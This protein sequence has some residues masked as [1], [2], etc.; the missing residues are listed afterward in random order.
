MQT[1]LEIC[2]SNAII[3]TVLAALAAGISRWRGR[4]A[5]VHLL[6]V[7]VLL[8]LITPPVMSLPA[9]WPTFVQEALAEPVTGRTDIP[10]RSPEEVDPE[11]TSPASAERDQADENRWIHFPE[12]SPASAAA[13]ESPLRESQAEGETVL[14][15][16]AHGWG[17]GSWLAWVP[18]L[19]LAGSLVWFMTA[20]LRIWRFHR[21][22]HFAE[23]APER[24]QEQARCL[25]ESV[26]LARCP[27]IWVVPGRISPLLWAVGSRVRLVLPVDL[28]DRLDP[29]QQAAL[30]A[31]E[32]AHARRHDHWVRWLELL[33]IGVYWWH[34]VA[35]WARRELQQA[36]EQCCDAWVTWLLPAAAKAY[37]KALLQTVDFLD[38]RP[39]L[40]PVASGAGHVHLLKRRLTMIAREPFC[41][42]LPWA[43]LVGA[44]LLAMLVLPVGLQRLEATSPSTQ[45]AT[46]ASDD[47]EQAPDTKAQKPPS[48]DL[49]RRLD[50]LEEKMERVLKALEAQQRGTD[51]RPGGPSARETTRQA[52]EAARLGREVEKRDREVQRRIE[53]LTK[54]AQKRGK[55]ARKRAEEVTEE[56]KK[57][58]KARA[59]ESKRRI[60]IDT[61]KAVDPEQLKELERQINEAVKETS[62]RMKQLEK[63]IEETVKKS[64]DPERMKQLERQIEETINKSINPERMEKLARQIE[65]AV[66]KSLNAEERERTRRAER[67]RAPEAPKTPRSPG[68][69][70]ASSPTRDQRD[71]ERRLERLE[72]KMEKV[73]QALEES[74]KRSN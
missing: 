11:L 44:V 69:A 60:V 63:E 67:P 17:I 12:A 55:E 40:P 24:L 54:E 61:S 48:R 73:L 52:D 1:F 33:V 47:E 41:P 50:A 72:E 37:A 6:W 10:P 34:P 57:R 15:P 56:A 70:P 59:E 22:L 29:D 2:L 13:G 74:R 66:T 31:H 53:E 19:W 46:L 62:E 27:S 71:L 3:A 18:A 35:W 4:P 58:A 5:L 28:L 36:E 21:V 38:A 20:G 7:L 45:Q 64:I 32:L 39:A 8:K 9:A 65:E 23:P 42:R 14:P 30:L 51:R 16:A 49:E 43:V 68:K 26:G 25:A